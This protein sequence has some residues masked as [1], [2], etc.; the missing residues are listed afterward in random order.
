MNPVFQVN[1]DTSS[2][3]EVIQAAVAQEFAKQSFI[4]KLP[5]FLRRSDL[6]ELLGVGDTKVTEIF[7]RQDFPVCRE[8]GHPFVLSEL[9]IQW[10]KDHTDWVEENASESLIRKSGVA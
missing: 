6:K 9:F 10:V 1:L 5:T 4:N 2:I 7:N 8:L 3:T